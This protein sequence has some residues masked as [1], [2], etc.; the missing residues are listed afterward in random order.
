MPRTNLDP[1][2]P[3]DRDALLAREATRVLDA[4]V[5]GDGA[6]KMQIIETGKECTALDL[7]P[8]A[9]A[10]L[11]TMLNEMAAGRAVTIVPTDA[12][13]TTGEAADLLHVSRPFVVG[14]IDKGELPARM[15]GAHRRMRLEDV[16]AYKRESKARARKALKEMAA[17]S[18][19]LGL[20]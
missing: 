4:R 3:T 11:R 8:A 9:A 17:I 1:T 16:L 20:E 14:L 7:P 18:Q 13:I 12:E 15:V 19:E 5:I 6:L 2:I 10:L